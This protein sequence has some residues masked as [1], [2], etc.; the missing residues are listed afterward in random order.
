MS[1]PSK[2][3]KQIGVNIPRFAL[4][5]WNE[6]RAGYR[7]TAA[8]IGA[9]AWF[10]ALDDVRRKH[11]MMLVEAACGKNAGEEQWAPVVDW[12]EGERERVFQL[13]KSGA[14]AR[15]GDALRKPPGRRTK[16]A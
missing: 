8:V 1:P 4:K 7:P 16:P 12:V 3:S 6:W 14:K 11:L 10:A 5:D 9:M 2:S 13:E 15:L